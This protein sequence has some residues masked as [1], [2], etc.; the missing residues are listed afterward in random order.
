MDRK[1]N[2]IKDEVLKDIRPLFES[3]EDHYCKP[4]RTSNDFSSN[5]I[6]HE[7]NSDK[8]K[9]LSLKEY[10]NK[11]RP[12]L[13]NMINDLKTQGEWKIES[14]MEINFMSYNVL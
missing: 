7:S 11:I 1:D 5:F 10:L 12:Y 2:T 6:K 3:D 13:S 9:S 14:R 8:N 4:I